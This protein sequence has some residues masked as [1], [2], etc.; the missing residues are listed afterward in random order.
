MP[1]VERDGAR[2]H[3]REEGTGFPVVLHTGGAG[4]GAMW[5]GAGYTERL[6]GFRLIL[7]DHRGRGRSSRIEGIDAHVPAEYVADVVATADAVG[8]PAFGF[9]G[10]SMGAA[11]G[12]RLAATH[13]D[14]VAALVSIGGVADDPG[15]VDDPAELI[16]LLEKGG[17]PALSRAIAAEEG[18]LP[19]WLRQNFD[20]TDVDQFILSLRAW[21]QVGDSTWDDLGRIR[22]PTALVAG[23]GEAP[24]GSLERMGA[25]IPGG[26]VTER[27]EGRG[28][29]GAFLDSEA[30]MRAALPVLIAGREA[31]PR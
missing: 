31:P 1:F 27:I 28:H 21:A 12:Y 19:E 26:A 14:R 20:E 7:V 22:C 25:A 8:A 29:V 24:P 5:D 17:A 10:Y 6:A 9:V 4:D 13:G 15:E 30:V 18:E 23:S 2:L 16:D 3:Y 11:V